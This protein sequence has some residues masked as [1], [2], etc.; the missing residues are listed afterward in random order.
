MAK[1]KTSKK[2]PSK[3]IKV[4][5][6]VVKERV[7]KMYPILMRTYPEAKCS[8]DHS[9]PLELLISTILAAQCTDARVNIVAKDIYKKY[10]SARD[11]ANA[12]VNEIERDIKSTG[13]YRNKA[14]SIKNAC[15]IIIDKFG[16]KVPDTMEG[17]LELP[18]VGRKTANVIL[19]NVYNVQGIICDTHMIRLSRRL[20]L[21]ENSDPVKL[22]YDLMEVVPKARWTMFSHL[23]VFH[24]R[25]ICKAR[26][27]DCG[28]CPITKYCPA[29]FDPELW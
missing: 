6:S 13:F 14:R 1:K 18:G 25:S 23:I 2:K 15:Q 21:S 29:A 10:T 22:E 27:P 5:R 9:S 26:K 4:D 12:D 20:G 7:K 28:Q 8:L 16:G 11:W 19:G 24:G 3:K 17:L